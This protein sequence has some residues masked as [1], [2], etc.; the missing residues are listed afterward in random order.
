M[1]F[2]CKI[3]VLEVSCCVDYSAYIDPHADVAA[4]QVFQD[5]GLV[6]EGEVGHVAGLVELWRVHLLNVT[7]LHGDSLSRNE[8]HSSGLS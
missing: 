2:V 7:H 3:S 8:N 5:A 6:E 1:I 4:A